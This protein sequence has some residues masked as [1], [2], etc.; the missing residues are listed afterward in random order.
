MELRRE[1][2]LALVAKAL[3]RSVIYIHIGR[4][5]NLRIYRVR[6]D[7]IAV[8][9]RGNID[10]PGFQILHR[11]ISSPVSVFHLL[12][13]EAGSKR[14]QLM[15]HADRID[16]HIRLVKFAD[17]PD[18]IR[19]ILG[20]SGTV[21]QHNPVRMAGQNLFCLCPGRIHRDITASLIQRTDNIVLHTEIHQRHLIGAS[22]AFSAYRS[23]WI[24]VFIGGAGNS[25]DNGIRRRPELLFCTGNL[26]H[27]I[28]GSVC[29]D[30]WKNLL[31]NNIGICGDHSIHRT[32]L[33]KDLRQS[34]GIN[35]FDP[36]DIVALQKCLNGVFLPE[37]AGN[38]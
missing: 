28:S 25:S 15:S 6:I 29:P 35:A 32:G 9:L 10:P 37:I 23:F 5:R 26:F 16:R 7:D 33:T 2:V 19:T 31:R 11:V 20:V 12:R 22:G 3:I 13:V 27:L 17:L 24:C 8:V 1:N 14:H 30:L 38:P 4:L 21:C 18:L 36:G 34:T